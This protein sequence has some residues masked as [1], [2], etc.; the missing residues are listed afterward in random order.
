M[1]IWTGYQ[2]V[3]YILYTIESFK[4]YFFSLRDCSLYV[5]ISVLHE[6][7][8][9]SMILIMFC[10][11]VLFFGF[12]EILKVIICSSGCVFL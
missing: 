7:V 6:L 10:S 4:D 12:R 3:N 11:F 8:N 2:L 5:S 9:S 1:D